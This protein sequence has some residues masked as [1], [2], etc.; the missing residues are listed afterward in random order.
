MPYSTIN[1]LPKSVKDNLPSHALNI[2]KEAFNNA[3]E[4]YKDVKNRK[5]AESREEA[6]FK[7]AWSAVKQS[8]TKGYDEKWHPKESSHA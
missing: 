4:E 1:E 8:Y 5:G 6:A 2:F 3:F 7:V